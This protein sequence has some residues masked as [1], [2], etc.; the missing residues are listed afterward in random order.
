MEMSAQFGMSIPLV[1]APMSGGPTTP[2]M[3]SAAA[4]AGALGL[5][6]AGYK[7][8][9]AVED[10]IKAVRADGIPFGVNV[11]APNPV[12]VDPQR[13]RA[14]ASI[15]AADADQFG[16]TL[17]SEPVEDNDRFDEKI[18]LLLDDPVPMVSFT[19]GIPSRDV[20]A[21]LQKAKSVVVQTVTTAEEAAQAHDAGVDMLAVQAAAAG[22]HSGTLSPL[23]PVT[24]VGIV[25]LVR[26]VAATVP[27]P[28]LATGGLAT[29][30]AVAE[31]IRAG[32]AAAAVG[33]VLLRATESGASATHQA[34]LADPAYT[35]TVL[36]RAFTG[37][38]ARGLRN[39]FIDAHE[40]EAPPGYPAIHHLTS[41]L[42]KAAAAAGQPDY[43]HLWAGTGFRHAT[44]EP[45]TD[46]LRRLASD[47]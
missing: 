44:A 35:E 15:I 43:V 40:A 20:I 12:P 5:L 17:P 11:F 25:D 26:Q 19:F 38:P 21:A 9:E 24:P 23:R 22:G 47:L 7:T 36:T 10:E 45:A 41:P 30:A 46:I 37:R 27:L 31:V 8:V 42:R 16:L 3:V 14:Y 6:A 18:E 28:V 29:P 33:T 13:Y 39:A 32:A 34:A 4:R 1:A 2:A